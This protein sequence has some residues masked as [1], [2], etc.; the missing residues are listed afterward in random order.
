MQLCYVFSQA[1]LMYSARRHGTV[2]FG[3]NAE[4]RQAF[5]SRKIVSGAC[6]RRLRGEKKEAGG[7][8]QKKGE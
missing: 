5:A 4:Q 7:R 8:A 3:A 1:L 6:R 2:A